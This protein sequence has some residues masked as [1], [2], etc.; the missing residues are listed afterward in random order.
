MKKTLLA[1]AAAALIGG[2]PA[3]HA[4]WVVIVDSFPK[5]G[6]FETRSR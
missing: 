4:Q 6:H 3:A 1:L 5:L 2:M